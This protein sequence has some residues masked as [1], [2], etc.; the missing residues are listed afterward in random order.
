MSRE[1]VNYLPIFDKKIRTHLSLNILLYK[2]DIFRLII[3]VGVH[4]DKK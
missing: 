3:K 4:Y 1:K 2:D